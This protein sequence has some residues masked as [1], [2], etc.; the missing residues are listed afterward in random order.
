MAGK[1]RIVIDEE[2]PSN[3]GGRDQLADTLDFIAE[4]V[5]RMYGDGQY[6]NWRIERIEEKQ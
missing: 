4:R 3:I 2:F 1:I 5:R 6:P